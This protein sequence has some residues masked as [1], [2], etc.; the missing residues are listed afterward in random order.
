[1][2]KSKL[3]ILHYFRDITPKVIAT[4]FVICILFTPQLMANNSG[5]QE[6]KIS[7]SLKATTIKQ[8]FSN[9]EGQ[10]DYAFIINDKA[11]G[12]LSKKVTANF[13]KEDI[14]SIL[15]VAFSNTNLTYSISGKQIIIS[16]EN[17][18]STSQLVTKSKITVTGKVLDETGEGLIGASVK[19]KNATAT[20]ITDVAGKY[21]ILVDSD[22][23]LI[24]SS[25]GYKP[26]E[27]KVNGNSTI[28]I[29]MIEDIAMLDELVVVGFATQK[30]ENLTGSVGIASAE[31]LKERP[32]ARVTQALQGL[33]PGLD[34]SSKGGSLEDR[35]S[36]N[37]RGRG[38]VG[39]MSNSAPLVLIDGME[40]S[41]HS[42]NPQDVA[43]ISVLKDAAASSIYGSR[44]PFGVILITTKSGEKGK[45]KINYNNSFRYSSPTKR[46][47]MLDSYTFAQYFNEAN[48]NG[49]GAP[50]FNDEYLQRIK[51]FQDGKIKETIIPNPSN[52]TVWGDGYRYGNDNVNWYDAMYKNWSFA[53][54]HNLS[55]SGGQDKINYYASMGYLDQDGL[56]KIADD[57]FKRYNIT[58][59]FNVD[60]TKWLKFTYNTRFSREDFSRPSALTST[61]YGDL[62]RQGWPTLPLYDPNGYYFSA[63]SPA[64]NMAEGGKDAAQ[65][66]NVF[67]QGTIRIEPIKQWVTTIDIN[68]HAYNQ[69][70]G[71]ESFATFN[72]DV[73]GNPYPSRKNSELNKQSTKTNFLN[74]NVY[75][76]YTVNFTSGHN[77]K[78]MLGFQLEDK[79][80]RYLDVTRAGI[81]DNNLNNLD[82]TTGLDADGKPVAPSING[83]TWSWRTAGFFGRL[84][85]D[86]KGRYLLEAN[87]RY[88]GTSRMRRDKRWQLLPS[89]S[90]GWN[91]AREDFWNDVQEIMGTFKLRGSYGVLGNQNFTSYYPTYQTMSLGA[92][93]GS[94]LQNGIKPNTAD[95]PGRTVEDWKWEKIKT[96]NLGIDFGFLNNRLTGSFDYFVRKNIDMIGPGET[97]PAIMGQKS[98]MMN[99]TDMKDYGFELVVAWRDYIDPIKVGYGVKLL[100][101]DSQS[102]VTR[103]PNA[104]GVHSKENENAK[105][106]RFIAGTK[107]GDIWGYETIGIAKTQA[108]MDAHLAT[109]AHGGQNAL[110]ANWGAGD[111]MYKDLNGDGKIDAGAGT[112]YNPGDMKVIGNTTP[113]YNFGLE[114]TA[115]WNGFDLRAFFQ[116]VMKRDVF[117]GSDWF[118]GANYSIWYS[119]GFKEHLDYFRDDANHRLGQNLN[120][121][122][123]RPTFTQ[124]NTQTQ[125]G[126]LQNAAYIRM[127]NIQLGYTLPTAVSQKVYLSNLRFFFSGENLWTGTNMAKM[128][129]PEVVSE[130]GGRGYPLSKVISFGLSATF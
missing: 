11:K 77:L 82:L 33:I 88:D 47:N 35:E 123:P 73:K 75:T 41:I 74:F 60:L 108:E 52:P 42:L 103:F 9:I 53:Q 49:G 85:Y 46:P 19:A 28:D 72:H 128:F 79:N 66:D 16:S 99:N 125:S 90:A 30:K 61:F 36:I 114:I 7:L 113:R 50:H 76:D 112:I 121:Y 23:T 120:A 71:W 2:K 92:A 5:E 27:V 98:P 4:M 70:R 115:D 40:G 25:I 100:L 93:S 87:L 106:R 64:L 68:Y 96:W 17:R 116:G 89:F 55:V 51:D 84:N 117:Q 107:I 124:K 20:A 78:G 94:W 102:K 32:V 29:A 6:K 97:K 3:K 22:E 118:W 86:Y 130:N 127:K 122:Y 95:I 38:T 63:P 56:L 34:I 18:P 69:S 67:Q 129:D 26:A 126:Y 105:D 59:K 31:D 1:M 119:T 21:S 37:I 109:L 39:I 65:S 14:S 57:K 58:A 91:I 83:N 110:G 80:N 13:N 43:S 101:S 24:F 44:A 8:L 10:S 48:V 62:G 15:D 54:E 45:T 111:I 104:E 81:L 12:E